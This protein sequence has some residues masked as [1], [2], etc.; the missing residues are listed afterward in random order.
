MK[1]AFY[2]ADFTKSANFKCTDVNCVSVENLSVPI[3][4]NCA[5]CCSTSISHTNRN[6]S[7]RLDYY[8]IY[9]AEGKFEV[10]VG[11]TQGTVEAGEILVIPPRHYYKIHCS[12]NP[13]YFLC[14]HFT[15]YNA[16]RILAENNIKVF[17]GRNCLDPNN[18]LLQRFKTL[19]EAFAKDDEFRSR[20]LACLLERLLIEAGRAKKKF[21]SS[22]SKLTKSIRYINENYIENIKISDLAQMETMCLTAYN[23]KFKAQM[24]MT[25]SNYI[26]ALRINMAKELL[27]TS[28][29]SIKE[30][31][32]I[33]GYDNFNF[34]ARI[35]KK[36]TGLSPTE[37]RKQK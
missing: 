13:V 36:H 31:S 30:I 5:S 6:H 35:F 21:A 4:V 18:H 1:N 17:P 20:E 7:G 29:I 28:S 10:I 22:S 9:L 14:V 23:K 37:Y 27:E 3:M 26:I 33:C 24:G 2:S 11:K 12:G 34:F 25:P 16:E 19:F 8:F 32:S 15:G